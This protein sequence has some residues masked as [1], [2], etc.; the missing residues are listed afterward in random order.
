[1][2]RDTDMSEKF[3]KVELTKKQKKDGIKTVYEFNERGIHTQV[4]FL[5]F[6]EYYLVKPKELRTDSLDLSMIVHCFICSN[7][8][9]ELKPLKF[10]EKKQFSFE[11][12]ENFNSLCTKIRELYPK[13][14]S[15][16]IL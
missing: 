8:F 14:R 11:Q 5:E 9:N 2:M 4:S 10:S 7:L 1:M 6:G 12:H 15:I 16:I 13:G 3:R